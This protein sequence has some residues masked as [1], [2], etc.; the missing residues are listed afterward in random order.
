MCT[1]LLPLYLLMTLS[2]NYN[3]SFFWATNSFFSQQ[4]K[5]HIDNANFL[6]HMSQLIAYFLNIWLWWRNNPLLKLIGSI[7]KH[8]SL[9]RLKN[10]YLV[11]VAW[12]LV[13]DQR[14]TLDL[15]SHHP[16]KDMKQFHKFAS[17]RCLTLCA[18]ERYYRIFCSW[19]STEHMKFEFYAKS[20]NQRDDSLWITFILYLW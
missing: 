1:W 17:F 8:L 2:L 20:Q 6:L 13:N 19:Y 5:F 14:Y 7:D 16:I 11:T 18:F 3:N 15:I 4:S 10:I 12:N 9:S